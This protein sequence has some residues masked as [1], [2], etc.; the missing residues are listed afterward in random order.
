MG[1]INGRMVLKPLSSCTQ[2]L[3]TAGLVQV[4]EIDDGLPGSLQPQRVAIYLDKAVDKVHTGLLLLHPMNI[5]GIKLLQI[6][7]FVVVN[8]RLDDLPLPGGLC[9]SAGKIQVLNDFVN[10]RAIHPSRLPNDFAHHSV[11]FHQL[12]VEPEG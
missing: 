8:Q 4:L 9:K 10:G 6:S 11:L 2:L 5:V 7:G 1:G 3:R 12:G